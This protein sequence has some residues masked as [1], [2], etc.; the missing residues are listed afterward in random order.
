MILLEVITLI[1][2]NVIYDPWWI[3]TKVHI[4]ILKIMIIVK[5]KMSR[6]YFFNFKIYISHLET[7]NKNIKHFFPS[8][9]IFTDVCLFL[10]FFYLTGIFFSFLSCFVQ[11][12][13]W[14]LP[15]L[16]SVKSCMSKCKRIFFS[17]YS[18]K[19]DEKECISTT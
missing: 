5:I 7:K 14:L 8:Y 9:Y 10:L 19:F 1:L 11:L 18:G 13:D 6:F 15:C 16:Q 17:V 2:L 4:F 3:L 12:C